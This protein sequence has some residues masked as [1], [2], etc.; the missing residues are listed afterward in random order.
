MDSA[1][2]FLY[3]S[4]R[5]Y[6]IAEHPTRYLGFHLLKAYNEKAALTYSNGSAGLDDTI[7]NPW[8]YRRFRSLAWRGDL[9]REIEQL[10]AAIVELGAENGVVLNDPLS[11]LR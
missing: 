4:A 10:D 5:N 1:E 7:H 11:M 3:Y 6:I 2:E 8:L 9:R